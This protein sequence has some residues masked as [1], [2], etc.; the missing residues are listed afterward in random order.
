MIFAYFQGVISP[1]GWYCTVLRKKP[2]TNLQ[3]NKCVDR[4]N[5][6]TKVDHI[7]IVGNKGVELVFETMKR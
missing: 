4:N 6:K 7:L 3:K 2:Y 5:F 1:C